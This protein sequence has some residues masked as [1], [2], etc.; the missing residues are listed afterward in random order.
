MREK[1]PN[2]KMQYEDQIK[3]LIDSFSDRFSDFEKCKL[4]I[5]LFSNPFSVDVTLAPENAQLELIDLQSSDFQKNEF[6]EKALLDF[7]KNLP[8]EF[9]FLKNNASMYATMFGSTY[10]CEQTFSLMTL[11]KS[12]TRNRLTDENLSAVLHIA[13]ATVEPN[14]KRI[15]S[16]IQSQPSH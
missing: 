4:Q 15:A 9:S 10:I 8:D 13:T 3:I 14:I 7:Y 6:Q 5:D 16:K 11:N 2:M 1:F 12:K